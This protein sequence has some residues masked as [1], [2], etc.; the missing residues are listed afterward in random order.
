M[1]YQELSGKVIRGIIVVH[2]EL[3]PG[4]LES[5]YHKALF[6]ELKGQGLRV[7][8]NAPFPVFHQ[9]KEVGDYF[10]DLV[11]E[12]KIILEVKA[13]RELT[14][15][16]RAQLINYLRLAGLKVS[17]LVNFC[18]PSLSVTRGRHLN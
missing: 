4:L 9:G 14:D 17:L 1:L 10:A 16:H 2:K 11:V 6:Y 8:Y 12:S 15:V 18:Y 5:P 7:L 13:L 3:G